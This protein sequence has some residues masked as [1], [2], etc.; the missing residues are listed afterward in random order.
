MCHQAVLIGRSHFLTDVDNFLFSFPLHMS[1][2]A[3]KSQVIPCLSEEEPQPFPPP[4]PHPNDA[5]PCARPTPSSVKTQARVRPLPAARDLS[6]FP[7]CKQ[8]SPVLLEAMIH[9]IPVSCLRLL[10]EPIPVLVSM[11]RR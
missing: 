2:V 3:L 1:P 7:L 9:P 6:A 11:D 8:A 5:V 10:L 4:L